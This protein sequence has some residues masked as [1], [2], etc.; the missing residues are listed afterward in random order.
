[1]SIAREEIFGPV[2]S[3]ISYRDEAEAVQIANDSPYGLHA[4]VATSDVERGQKVARQIRAGR[5]MINDIIDAPDAPFGGFKQSGL[6]RE[7]GR[8]GIAAYLEPQAIFS[9]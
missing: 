4:Y 3:L 9:K 7:F 8:F 1:M 2:L 5:V 6:G